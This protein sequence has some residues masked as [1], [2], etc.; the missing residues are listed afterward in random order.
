MIS[1]FKKFLDIDYFQNLFLTEK[2][3]VISFLSSYHFDSIEMKEKLKNIL[4]IIER[5]SC[6]RIASTD[7]NRSQVNYLNYVVPGMVSDSQ[8]LDDYSN[9]THEIELLYFIGSKFSGFNEK[10]LFITT[11]LFLFAEVFNFLKVDDFM[12][13]FTPKDFFRDFYWLL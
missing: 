7:Y 13:Q 6:S 11:P 9:T 4:K 3:I 8:I 5:V 12:S 1:N 2:Y 10:L